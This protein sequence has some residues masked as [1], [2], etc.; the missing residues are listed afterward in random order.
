MVTVPVSMGA[1]SWPVAVALSRCL[2]CH[3]VAPTAPKDGRQD[4]QRPGEHDQDQKSDQAGHDGQES[5]TARS[6]AGQVAGGFSRD[7]ERA[8][9]T[10]GWYWSFEVEAAKRPA[11]WTRPRLTKPGRTRRPVTARHRSL[12]SPIFS[13]SGYA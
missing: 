11:W 9:V 5:F 10:G 3:H 12:R 7:I 2:R 6:S 4:A 13:T 1:P 8:H